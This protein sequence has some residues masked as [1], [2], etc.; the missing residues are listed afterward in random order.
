MTDL[1]IALYQPD[2]P[3]NTGTIL[4][5]AA[6]LGLGV[7]VIEPAGFDI[8]DR[9][10]RRAG[11]DYLETV[12]LQRHVNWE[13]F[14]LWRQQQGRRLILATTKSSQPYP[15]FSFRSDDILLFGRESAGVPDDVHQA[16]DGRILIPMMEGQRSIN[17]AMS[18]AMIAG[19]AMRVVR[20]FGARLRT[21]LA[22]S[23]RSGARS[24]LSG[25][26]ATV[27]LQSS[28]ATALMTAS[29]AERGLVKPRMAQIVLLGAN[30]G[31]AVT[32]WLV[33]AG[34]EVL[35]PL[36]LLS[37]AGLLRNGTTKRKGVGTALIGIGLMLLS[38]QLLAT[39]TEPMRQSPAL[40]AF[41]GMLD[42]AWIVALIF[43]AALAFVCSSS[44]AVV[45]LVLSL[46]SS[47]LVSP[48]LVV[49]LIL[50]AN[51]GG[52]VPP[53]IAT[54]VSPPEARRLT[55]ANLLVRVTGCL[56][57]LPLCGY[58]AELLQR[59]PGSAE[60]LAVDAHLAFNILLALSAWP[61]AGPLSRLMTRLV[62]HEAERQTGPL[63]LD[64]EALDDP[65]R[66]L[67]N[68][69]RE[70][71]GVGDQIERMLIRAENAFKRNDP[72]PLAEIAAIEKRVDKLQQEVKVYLS[73]LGRKGL[74]EENARR[75]VAI[76][77]YAINLEHI[78]DIVEKGLCEQLG[79]KIAM[80][81]QF[82]DDGYQELTALLDL[83]IDNLRTAQ[84]VFVTGDLNL[85]RRLM[86]IKIPGADEDPRFWASGISL[87]AHPVNPNVPTV[88]MNTRMV[89]TSSHW[90]GGGADLTPML[91]DRRTQDDPDSQL[92][93]RVMEI[94]CNRH[95][96]VA[97]YP[98]YKAWCD[99]Y[100]FVK[101][102]NE[103]RGIGGI[104]FDWLQSV[105][106]AGG[107]D[108]DFA[109]V[110][111]VGRAFNLVYPR[112]VRANFN[113]P[114]SEQ[115]RDEQLVQ[116]GRYVEFNLLY[117][118]GTIFGLKTG[119]NV[120]SILSSLPPVVRWP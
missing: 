107:W 30:V 106:D 87:I 112:I 46:A 39:A 37:G 14:A 72:A 36:L 19:E 109:F 17:V 110:Q 45:V 76:I 100:F 43:S 91:N 102:R 53:V 23:T 49:V 103:P 108:A 82:S 38:L 117:D 11:M 59:L 24:F 97:D 116:R 58:A 5:L 104:F 62:P 71:L 77:D 25:L 33:A 61:L 67:A 86:E 4:R 44:L 18:A 22:S 40:A 21:G 63:F 27:A 57:A 1:R 42:S 66:A 68:A 85:A 60:K 29:F 79:K 55:L 56:I 50:G 20:A 7:D 3:G 81:L 111:D 52:A 98:R 12:R 90:F 41:L 70:V 94:T 73:K 48:G 54:L 31:T 95:Q 28:T 26:V 13:Q 34:T 88:H 83:T 113:A 80:G 75:S 15:Q 69:T 78:G 74:D 64:E 2:I 65:V 10:L 84:T 51:L 105:P 35:A 6:C 120:E 93:H 118:R 32:A 8:S 115:Q 16:S 89:V 9:N 119:G 114:W 96:A 101:H 92:F 99:D 47:G